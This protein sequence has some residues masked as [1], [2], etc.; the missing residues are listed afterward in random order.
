MKNVRY[1]GLWSG[2]VFATLIMCSSAWGEV[3]IAVSEEYEA[4]V[5]RA[6]SD[7]ENKYFNNK[8]L[9]VT[10]DVLIISIPSQ[11]DNPLIKKHFVTSI[12]AITFVLDV[13]YISLVLGYGYDNDMAIYENIILFKDILLKGEITPIDRMRAIQD[14]NNLINTGKEL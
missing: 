5:K 3:K 10:N 7:I 11:L 13:W 2:L 12:V 6:I 4:K 14:A 1:K 8:S 9:P